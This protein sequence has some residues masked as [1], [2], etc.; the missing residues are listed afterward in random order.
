KKLIELAGPIL[1]DTSEILEAMVLG[2][3]DKERHPGIEALDAFAARLRWFLE[4]FQDIERAT[5]SS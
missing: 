4:K 3:V 2:L 5:T 1:A